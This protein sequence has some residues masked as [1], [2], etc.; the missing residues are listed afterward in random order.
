MLSTPL[1]REIYVDTS[2]VGSAL[3]SVQVCLKPWTCGAEGNV[4]ASV[5]LPCSAGTK[6][7]GRFS[8]LGAHDQ[9]PWDMRTQI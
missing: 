3:V 1:P 2:V 7:G 9:L 4:I 5:H 6:A 8:M